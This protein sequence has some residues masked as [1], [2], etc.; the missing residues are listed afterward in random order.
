MHVGKLGD[1]FILRLTVYTNAAIPIIQIRRKTVYM[2]FSTS[3]NSR[4]F[5]CF[6]FADLK[7]YQFWFGYIWNMQSVFPWFLLF[8]DAEV[9]Y[10]TIT[11][12]FNSSCSCKNPIDGLSLRP[13]KN[14]GSNPKCFLNLTSWILGKRPKY[15]DICYASCPS[16]YMC[17][18]GLFTGFQTWVNSWNSHTKSSSLL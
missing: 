8:H 4:F 15:S 9:M 14:K 5:D 7:A 2:G 6:Q 13:T 3:Q 18:T 10:S 12:W 11:V 1:S 16:P 17:S